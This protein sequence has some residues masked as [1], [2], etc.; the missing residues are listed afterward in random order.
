V[1][2][3][4]SD[5]RDDSV[6]VE[7]IIQH[8]LNYYNTGTPDS[9]ATLL[10][11]GFIQIEQG[12]RITADQYLTTVKGLKF[13]NASITWQRPPRIAVGSDLASLR[14]EGVMSLSM[15]NQPM[16]IHEA[17]VLV[18]RRARPRWQI[19]LWQIDSSVVASG[20]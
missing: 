11:P 5:P 2:A 10:A 4:A 17:G 8:V 3:A 13:N 18:L 7:G 1:A 20:K 12:H 15:G 16:M 6:A 9:I 19:A 14:Y